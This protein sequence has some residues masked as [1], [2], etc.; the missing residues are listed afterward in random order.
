MAWLVAGTA[1]WRLEARRYLLTQH[2]YL[3]AGVTLRE[4]SKSHRSPGLAAWRSGRDNSSGSCVDVVVSGNSHPSGG[5]GSMM[6]G[7]RM[8]TLGIK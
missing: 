2:L 8:N 1:R 5:A 6:C 7:G 3:G 4:L